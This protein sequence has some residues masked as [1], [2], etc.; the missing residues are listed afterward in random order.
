MSLKHTLIIV[1]LLLTTSVTPS[2]A[3]DT[4]VVS[5]T[6]S[7]TNSP[8]RHFSIKEFKK[9]LK[10]DKEE[11]R[12]NKDDDKLSKKRQDAQ[13]I[14][15]KIVLQLSK[16]FDYLSTIKDRLQSK[17]T[18]LDSTRN[19]SA[20]NT[21]LAEY[22]PTNYNLHLTTLK[23]NLDSIQ[24]SNQPSSLIPSLRVDAKV[25]QNDL[26]SLHQILVDTLKLIIKS[27][28]ITQ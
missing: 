14:S 26:K 4:P 1:T 11:F 24:S 18:S 2:F 13:K 19:M 12:Q 10:N 23:T 7:P 20:A 8:N 21:R 9:V 27:P 28:K 6:F 3:V 15:E 17:I 25:V 5:P 22:I 16:R